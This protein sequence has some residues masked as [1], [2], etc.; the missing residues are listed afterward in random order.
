MLKKLK[1]KLGQSD[2]T[3]RLIPGITKNLLSK[4]E[5]ELK[6]VDIETVSIGGW[7]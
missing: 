6:Y 1:L 3:D 5:E 4:G 7:I 2:I